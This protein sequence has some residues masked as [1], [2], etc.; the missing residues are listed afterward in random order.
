MVR[1]PAK[2]SSASKRALSSAKKT[3]KSLSLH[4]LKQMSDTNQKSRRCQAKADELKRPKVRWQ[5]RVVVRF[6]SSGG[7]WS[8]GL[9]II[10]SASLLVFQD[11][12]ELLV[13]D[14]YLE[15]RSDG[16]GKLFLAIT[17]GVTE[18]PPEGYDDIIAA[19]AAENKMSKVCI[20]FIAVV[21][22]VGCYNQH[23]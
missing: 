3:K 20:M 11:E 17:A 4:R 13:Q 19:K 2:G 7:R 14:G 23:T 10:S 8:R 21:I 9:L 5:H 18:L 6:T 1:T 16:Q 12:V 15:F 22:W